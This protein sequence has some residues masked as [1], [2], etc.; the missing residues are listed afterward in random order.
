MANLFYR[1]IFLVINFNLRK[2]STVLESGTVREDLGCKLKSCI[3]QDKNLIVKTN[4]YNKQLESQPSC[5]ITSLMLFALWL[6]VPNREEYSYNNC[7]AACCKKIHCSSKK[8]FALL[9]SL[10]KKKKKR[11]KGFREVREV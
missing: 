6:C 7:A 2:D 4:V 1:R 9:S 8:F 5:N 3:K 10:L 11:E